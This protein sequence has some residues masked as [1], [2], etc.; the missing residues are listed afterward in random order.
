MEPTGALRA[1]IYLDPLSISPEALAA[2]QPEAIQTYNDYVQALRAV[3]QHE[4]ALKTESEQRSQAAAA[5]HASHR[6]AKRSARS[7]S[8][9]ST[10]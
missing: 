8:R 4:T 5:R 1:A 3:A 9:R 6:S 7:R 2:G 10:P